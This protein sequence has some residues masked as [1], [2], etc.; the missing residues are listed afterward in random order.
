LEICARDRADMRK[1]IKATAGKSDAADERNCPCI[2]DIGITAHSS[3]A[4]VRLCRYRVL[5]KTPADPMH[6]RSMQVK[7]TF[8]FCRPM[9]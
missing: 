7:R 4:G 9:P 2:R 3:T 1:A 6:L 5:A 8:I